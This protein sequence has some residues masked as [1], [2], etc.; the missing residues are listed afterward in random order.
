MESTQ[1]GETASSTDHQLN[2]ESDPDACFHQGDSYLE[3]QL[4]VR[5]RLVKIEAEPNKPY[6]GQKVEPVCLARRYL[7]G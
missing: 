6:L 5:I 7:P 4:T 2:P 3:P 1:T